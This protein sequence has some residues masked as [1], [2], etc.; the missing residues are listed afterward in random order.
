MSFTNSILP[1]IT[2]RSLVVV[3]EDILGIPVIE[4]P[5]E[6]AE[7]DDFVECGLCG[8]AA[9]ISP[10]HSITTK[11][12]MYV[13]NGGKDESGPVMAKLRQTLVDIQA[14]KIEGPEGWVVKIADAD[15]IPW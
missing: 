13:F 11:G 14:G 6:L 8:T 1:S 9:V 12:P 5:V 4:R 7:V 15:S 10:F 3:A 2:R